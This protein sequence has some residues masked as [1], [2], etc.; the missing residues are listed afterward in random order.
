MN[1]EDR[2]RG[3][4]ANAADRAPL[5]PGISA[6]HVEYRYRSRRHRAWAA[7]VTAVAVVLAGG[8][9]V[10]LKGRDPAVPSARVTAAV[11]E[12]WPQAIKKMP[13]ARMTGNIVGLADDH[14]VLIENW[15]ND[16]QIN[17]IDAYD[18]DT[19][20]VRRVTEK[21]LDGSR[22]GHGYAVGDGQVLWWYL[23]RQS[24]EIVAAPISGGPPRQVGSMPMDLTTEDGGTHVSVDDMVDA[25]TVIDGQVAFSIGRGGVYTVPLAGGAVQPVAGAEGMH[26]LRWPWVGSRKIFFSPDEVPFEEILD[27]RS[28]QRSTA[29]IHPGERN[30]RCGV[31]RCTGFKGDGSAFYRLRSGSHETVLPGVT[32]LSPQIDDRFHVEND[33]VLRDL[34]T[35][36]SA[37]LNMSHYFLDPSLDQNRMLLAYQTGD[38]IALVDLTKIP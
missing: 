30:V 5:P 7:V 29:V 27:M 26:L 17:V 9:V 24:I 31:T 4:L 14:T 16:K 18:L 15:L 21:T 1:L 8:L 23:S 20:T 6:A 35:G 38:E 34:T 37:D 36:T 12:V 10:T 22:G 2:L 33:A 3:T 13:R 19:G 32:K 11:E 28:G 25:I